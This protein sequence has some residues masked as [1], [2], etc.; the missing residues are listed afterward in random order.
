MFPQALEPLIAGS[1]IL[2]NPFLESF[3]F[4]RHANPLGNPGIHIVRLGWTVVRV[5]VDRAVDHLVIVTVIVVVIV[6]SANRSRR[7]LWDRGI[8][9]VVSRRVLQSFR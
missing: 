9:L 3:V 6:M 1:R 7:H 2:L 5:V 4:K 8:H